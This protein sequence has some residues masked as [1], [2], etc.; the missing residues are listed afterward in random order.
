MT[1]DGITD[2]IFTN[3]IVAL[4]NQSFLQRNLKDL[5]KKLVRIA[6]ERGKKKEGISPFSLKAKEHGI[7]YQGGKL[8]DAT[9]I[10]AE[11]ENIKTKSS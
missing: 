3:E 7:R 11:V 8:D 1:S 5:G 9:I 2:N 4:A 10:V 6:A